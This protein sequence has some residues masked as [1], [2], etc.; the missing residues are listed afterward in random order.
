MRK[1]SQGGVRR[2]RLAASAK[3]AKV[4]SSEAGTTVSACS[5]EWPRRGRSPA[6]GAQA[7][8]SIA[9]SMR[10]TRQH[11]DDIGEGRHEARPLAGGG[12][13]GCRRRAAKPQLDFFQLLG[14][15][16]DL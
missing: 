9:A 16:A 8:R 11:G 10:M 15:L 12:D 7:S 3:N 13:D 1:L 4:S 14:Q 2:S 6:R 5:T